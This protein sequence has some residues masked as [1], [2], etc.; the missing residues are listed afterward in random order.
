MNLN[1]LLFILILLFVV[2]VASYAI[3][4]FVNLAKA[5]HISFSGAGALLILFLTFCAILFNI[6]KTGNRPRTEPRHG[7]AHRNANFSN[8][9]GQVHQLIHV[10]RVNEILNRLF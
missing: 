4:L 5:L 10:N 7:R 2:A 8:N 6:E 3:S 1:N 9:I